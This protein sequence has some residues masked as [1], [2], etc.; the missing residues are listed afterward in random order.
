MTKFEK[1]ATR[2]VGENA[3]WFGGV[4]MPIFLSRRSI[5]FLPVL[6]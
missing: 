1:Y 5:E 3:D 6:L 4:G 2:D